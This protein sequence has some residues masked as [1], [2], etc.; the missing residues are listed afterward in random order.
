MIHGQEQS[1]KILFMQLSICEILRNSVEK[2]YQVLS[3]KC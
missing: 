3:K 2:V 1:Q